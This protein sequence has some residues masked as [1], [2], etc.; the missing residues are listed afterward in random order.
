MLF[1]RVRNFLAVLKEKKDKFHPPIILPS[2]T[3]PP[4]KED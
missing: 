4:V 3:K 1:F 2:A